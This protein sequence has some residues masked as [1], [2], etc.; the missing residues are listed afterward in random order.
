MCGGESELMGG[1]LKGRELEKDFGTREEAVMAID[2][3]ASA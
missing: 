2:S 3:G 1:E